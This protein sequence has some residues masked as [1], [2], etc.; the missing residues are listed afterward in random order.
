MYT[1]TYV[2]LYLGVYCYTV[3][4]FSYF[5]YFSRTTVSIFSKLKKLEASKLV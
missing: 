2:D 5:L 3:F 4:I 1:K